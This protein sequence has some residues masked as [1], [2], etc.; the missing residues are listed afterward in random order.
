MNDICL[1][2]ECKK[3]NLLFNEGNDNEAREK[4]IE[5]LDKIQSNNSIIDSEPKE[6]LTFLAHLIYI[7]IRS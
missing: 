7:L 4:L 3:I 5:L 1:F 6:H 2:D